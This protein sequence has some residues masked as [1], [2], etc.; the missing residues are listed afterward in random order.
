[1]P[2][3]RI[4]VQSRRP[5]S[6]AAT[7]LVPGTPV[8]V[9][10]RKQ[11]QASLHLIHFDH[12]RL[13]EV[14]GASLADCQE[15]LRA[16]GVTWVNVN[17]VHDVGLIDTLG[18]LFGLHPMTREDIAD[19][20]QRPKWEEFPSY[21]F[22][23][24]KMLGV[25]ETTREVE[26][27]HVS[28][29]LGSNWVLTFLE[30]DGDVFTSVRSRIRSGNGRVRKQG[31]DYLAF[32]LIDA[33]IDHYF[34]AVEWTGDE[35]ELFDDHV[36]NN[37]NHLRIEEIHHFKRALLVLRRA[38]WPMREVMGAVMTSEGGL[39]RR[40]TH[41]FWRNLHDHAVQ[42][43]DLVETCRDTLASLQDTYLSSL[44][45]RMNE[46]MK[47]LTIISTIFIP[48]T[49]IAGVYGMNFQHMPELSWR[50]GYRAV[51]ALMVALAVALMLMFRRRGW[52]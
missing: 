1:M 16:H 35:I 4:R 39:I 38:V 10:E 14:E 36:L 20:S 24:L 43:I 8:F 13:H 25:N 12:E 51:L 19:T 52:L 18:D 40:E 30:D 33:V 17:G 26:I 31:A 49:F 9:G 28:L 34:L 29:I 41:V 3:S 48:L 42:V 47:T 46:V 27:E 45:N 11:D 2:P 50:L 15:R 23:A 5:S 37:P 6:Q 32:S 21:G 44:S 22:M 7:F